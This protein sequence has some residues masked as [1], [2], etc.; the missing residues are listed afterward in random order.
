MVQHSHLTFAMNRCFW[1]AL[2]GQLPV[3]TPC[4]GAGVPH[5]AS[6]LTPALIRKLSGNDALQFGRSVSYD[7]KG[8]GFYTLNK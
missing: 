6:C 5:D 7:L 3:N 2:L 1:P 8:V 4:S